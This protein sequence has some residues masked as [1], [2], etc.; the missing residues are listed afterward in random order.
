M[1]LAKGQTATV[2]FGQRTAK[3][4]AL[5]DFNSE[6]DGEFIGKVVSEPQHDF[7]N[8]AEIRMGADSFTVISTGETKESETAPPRKRKR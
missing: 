1:K 3:V 8:G 5:A 4:E 7:S 6:T 2:R